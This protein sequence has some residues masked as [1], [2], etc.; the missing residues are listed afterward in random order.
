LLLAAL[1]D[2]AT[3]L[4]GLLDAEDV[5]RMLDALALGVRVERDAARGMSSC[6]ARAPSGACRRTFLATPAQ[7]FG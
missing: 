6:T 2:G 7:H 1:A 3:R 5:D 4:H